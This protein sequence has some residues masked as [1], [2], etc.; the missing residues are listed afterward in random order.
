MDRRPSRQR[1]LFTT[2]NFR[3]AVDCK[4]YSKNF[5]GFEKEEQ[6]LVF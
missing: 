5:I 4:Q 3:E 2:E 6:G 1:T